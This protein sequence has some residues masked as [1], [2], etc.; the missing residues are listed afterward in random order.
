MILLVLN[1]DVLFVFLPVLRLFF[2]YDNLLVNANMI[3]EVISD[4][5]GVLEL[6]AY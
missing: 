5:T 2:G 1:I 3:L 4:I 6:L